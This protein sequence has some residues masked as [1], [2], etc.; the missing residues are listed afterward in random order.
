MTAT[1]PLGEQVLVIMGASSGI[2]LVTARLAAARGAAVMLSA[3]NGRDLERAVQQIRAA[4]G[5]AEFTPA[6]V[7]DPAQVEAV[8]QAALSTFGR[9]DTWINNAAVAVYGRAMDVPLEDQRRQF[10]VNY[11]GQVYG[12]RMAV[13]H[14]REMGGTIINVA[15]ALADRAI[16]LQANYCAAKH[17]LKAFTDALRMELEA[18]D[19]P[20]RVS[21][22]KPGSVDTPMFDKARACLEVEPQPV[23]PVYAPEVTARAILACAVRPVRDVITGGMGKVISMAGTLAPG[24]TDRYMQRHTFASQLSDRPIAAGRPDNLWHPVAYDGGERGGN[25]DGR[26]KGTSLYTAAALNRGLTMALMA[27]M[28]AAALGV[29]MWRRRA[30]THP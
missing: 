28:A 18:D 26:V 23:P 4:G 13:T 8:A 3:R 16:P 5:R 2:G 7:S 22:V 15:S 25:Y 29:R 17:A 1:R 24:L 10:D 21:L 6:D 27:G 19:V 20:I 14:M 12:C 11:W 30:R 9:I